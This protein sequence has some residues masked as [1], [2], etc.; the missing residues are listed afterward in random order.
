MS[1]DILK[2][3]LNV[4]KMLVA[5]FPH[6]VMEGWVEYNHYREV[7]YIIHVKSNVDHHFPL[8]HHH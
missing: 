3:S 8:S 5:K 2:Q 4:C 6:V 1:I 7:F